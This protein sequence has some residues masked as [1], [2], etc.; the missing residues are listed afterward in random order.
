MPQ[1]T[2]VPVLLSHRQVGDQPE[3]PGAPH[4]LSAPVPRLPRVVRRLHRRVLSGGCCFKSRFLLL[5]CP[6]LFQQFCNVYISGTAWS[7]I[8]T[9]NPIL[10]FIML[11]R[12]FMVTFLIVNESVLTVVFQLYRILLAAFLYLRICSLLYSDSSF[13]QTNFLLLKVLNLR[14]S[15]SASSPIVCCKCV[16]RFQGQI[17]LCR[18]IKY[19][20][21]ASSVSQGHGA[22]TEK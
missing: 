8:I 16:A 19:T 22:L 7:Q 15:F 9:C 14:P 12:I 20:I 4:R 5:F 18:A 13:L 21:L 3:R 17:L 10:N 6:T 2:P 1:L 11:S